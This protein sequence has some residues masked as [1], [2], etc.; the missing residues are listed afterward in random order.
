MPLAVLFRDAALAVIDKPAGLAVDEDVLPL[1]ARELAPPG[2]RAWPRVVHRLDRGTSGC[3]ALAL[4]KAAERG[5][6]QALAAGTWRKRY[7]AVVQ[8]V[9]DGGASL[10]T[11]YGPDPRDPRRFTTRIDTP[12]RARLSYAVL[13]QCAGA[14]LLAVDL[15]T[16]RTHQ[17]RVQLAESGYPLLG[18]E[19][20]GVPDARIGRP[21]L[22][23]ERLAFPHP[24]TG[25]PL[26]CR[27][28]LPADFSTLLAE[29]GCKNRP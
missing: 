23:A 16:G 20:Y 28:A 21:A 5:F 22:H 29:L 14:A 9:P 12:R 17:I 3:L 18:D 11:A 4:N 24:V 10:D 26:E 27:A 13:D 6:G 7:L 15:D 1:A 19:V 2:G 25:E 8:G